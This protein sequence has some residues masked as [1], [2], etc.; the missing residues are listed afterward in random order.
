MVCAFQ[1]ES[2]Q[3]TS[4]ETMCV[5]RVPEADRAPASRP[6]TDFVTGPSLAA[7]A[8]NLTSYTQ[9]AEIGLSNTR[10]SAGSSPSHSRSS[11]L[12]PMPLEP[13]RTPTTM[14]ATR[15]RRPTPGTRS[16]PM[17]HMTRSTGPRRSRRLANGEPVAA[18]LLRVPPLLAP[19]R[20]GS[21]RFPKEHAH[22]GLATAPNS[23]SVPEHL[24]PRLR[25][26]LSTRR[27]G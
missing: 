19:Q 3:V 16:C 13:S 8:V 23:R 9:E 12:R 6:R 2:S 22:N 18:G 21:L 14:A 11:G 25:G 15:C 20:R 4:F 24:A 26:A 5:P 17:G 27:R 1:P 10:R 7:S